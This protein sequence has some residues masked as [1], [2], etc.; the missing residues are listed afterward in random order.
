MALSLSSE[1][2]TLFPTACS[3][4]YFLTLRGDDIVSDFELIWR[5][6]DTSDVTLVV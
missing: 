3:I 4:Y 2:N 6:H 1:R 5:R